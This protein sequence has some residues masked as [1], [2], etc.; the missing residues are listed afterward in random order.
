VD[1]DDE[2]KMDSY[3]QVKDPEKMSM[4]EKLEVEEKVA[5]DLVRMAKGKEGDVLVTETFL[6]KRI[7]FPSPEPEEGAV[8]HLVSNVVHW[9]S[10]V[11]DWWRGRGRSWTEE[12]M[13]YTTGP[14][15]IQFLEKE[16]FQ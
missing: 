16:R 2:D 6:A 9:W 3:D 12:G 4:D 13:V 8:V 10:N 15:V 14:A 1:V 5:E 7:Y 11:V